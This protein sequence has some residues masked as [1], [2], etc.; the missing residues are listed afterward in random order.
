MSVPN[1]FKSLTDV[2][3]H[4]YSLSWLSIHKMLWALSGYSS[5]I[6]GCAQAVMIGIKRG[7]QM[8]P[9]QP[10]WI[11]HCIS[12]SAM[13]KLA[14][15]IGELHESTIKEWINSNE[16]FE[17]V[18]DNVDV[19]VGVRDIGSDHLKHLCHMFSILAV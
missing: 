4:R 16:S 17:F 13:L 6:S 15:K 2:I 19:S 8:Q 3:E 1:H 14:L 10:P 7:L 12:Y 18:G 5:I 9:M 11:P